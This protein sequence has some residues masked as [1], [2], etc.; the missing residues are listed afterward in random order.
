MPENKMETLEQYILLENRYPHVAKNIKL[1]WGSSYLPDYITNLMLDTRNGKR[2]GF[3]PDDAKALTDL[4]KIHD[5][6]YPRY[7]KY[8]IWDNE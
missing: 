6:V 5:D 4:L 2:K 1:F 7:I 3:P 8:E